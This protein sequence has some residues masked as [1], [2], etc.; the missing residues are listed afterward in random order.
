MTMTTA[1][2]LQASCSICTHAQDAECEGG[3]RP[4]AEVLRDI[5]SGKWASEVDAIHALLDFDEEEVAA[6][7]RRLPGALF[8]GTFSRR[9]KASLIARTGVLCVDLDGKS[10]MD[11]LPDSDGIAA[12]KAVLA[13]SPHVAAAFVSP[14]GTGLKVLVH[15]DTARS[16]DECFAACDR[17]FAAY[18]LT[19]D[20]ACKDVSRLCF[21]SHDANAYIATRTTALDCSPASTE[22]TYTLPAADLKPGDD[23]NLRGEGEVRELL[24][25]HGWKQHGP[26]GR[27][28]TR[29]GKSSGVSASLGCIKGGGFHCFTSNAAPFE[30]DK[31]YSLFGVFAVLECNG[32]F[33]AASSKLRSRGFGAERSK[34]LSSPGSTLPPAT[35]GT[36]PKPAGTPEPKPRSKSIAELVLPDASKKDTVNL[37]GDGFLR[38]GQA[39]LLAAPTGIGKSVIGLQSAFCWACGRDFFGI[40][41]QKPLRVLLVQSEN[42]EEDLAEMRE[43]IFG[44]IVFDP[45]EREA[46]FENV[47][48]IRSFKSGAAFVRDITP[49]VVDFKPDLLLGDPLFAFAGVD[50]SKDQ[51]AVSAFLRELVQPFVIE[52]NCGLI[53]THHTNKPPSGKEH[54]NWAAGDFAYVGSGHSE[55]ANFHRFVIAVRSL[56]SATVFEVRIGKRW[57]RAGIVAEDGRPTDR[58]LIQHSDRGICWIPATQQDVDRTADGKKQKSKGGRP[59]KLTPTMLKDYLDFHKLAE[60]T[61]KNRGDIAMHFGVGVSTVSDVWKLLNE[62]E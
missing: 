35:E 27:Y 21:V 46:I 59:P 11:T 48:V 17:Y 60:V 14:S 28:W 20:P 53:F 13:E 32:D 34:P 2:V 62:K 45:D 19:I 3:Q 40:K 49:D 29:P 7:K 39:G 31:S 9:A 47:R 36:E 12:V 24:R 1:P 51:A 18:G 55:L 56:G 26:S 44:G 6:A 25:A 4:I 15:V 10:N 43:G 23:F 54:G 16:H 38:R 8:S 52:H 58:F 30:G 57:K 42:D 61:R 5:V 33:R 37:L 41:P 22:T 50:L